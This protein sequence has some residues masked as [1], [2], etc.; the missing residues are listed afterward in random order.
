MLKKVYIIGIEKLL[1]AAEFGILA[2]HDFLALLGFL[3]SD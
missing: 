3:T 1:M 2:V